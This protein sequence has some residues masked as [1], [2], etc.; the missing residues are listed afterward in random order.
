MTAVS[1]GET[2][3]VLDTKK[4][5]DMHERQTKID[6]LLK[7]WRIPVTNIVNTGDMEVW[8]VCENNN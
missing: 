2:P 1:C 3:D 6:F 8:T 5:S 7:T 4:I